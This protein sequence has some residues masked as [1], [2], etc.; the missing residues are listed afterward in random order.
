MK[1][2]NVHTHFVTSDYIAAVVKA[3]KDKEDGFPMPTKYSL[4]ENLKVMDEAGIDM[5]ILSLSTPHPHF[6]DD[7]EA[8][9]LNRSINEQTKAWV[10]KYPERFGWMATLP[11]PDVE[12]SIKEAIYSLDV[13]KADG[14]RLSSNSRGV[15]LGDPLL[16]PLFEELNKHKAVI[17]IHPCRPEAVPGGCFTAGPMPLF[18]YL[19]DTTR[20]VI[21]L[22]TSG[23]MD[24][25]PDI[26]IIVP[27]SGSFLPSVAYRLA[28]ISEVLIP[29]G[30][31]KPCDVMG[32]VGK[33]YWDISGDALPHSLP[34][35]MNISTPDRC[36]YGLDY[37]HTP[38]N[39]VIRKTK[40]LKE[41]LQNSS[42]YG[43][44]AD[45]MMG[46]TALKLLGKK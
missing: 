5:S 1:V 31:M 42:E 26:K 17:I 10:D 3:G 8:C 21:N 2:V 38:P 4:E 37:P 44:Y 19:A 15:Y 43:K 20:T 27:H 22:I 36:M 11:L 25:Y 23:A 13:L 32:A 28:S 45:D 39:I 29:A 46:G 16:D 12:G 9:D 18:E 24:R 6:G 30:L 7:A 40:L 41:A 14:I 33:F 34:I 35:L